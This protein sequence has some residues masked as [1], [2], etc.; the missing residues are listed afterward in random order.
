MTAAVTD[1]QA[2]IWYSIGLERKLGRRAREVFARAE[3]R[4]AVVYVPALVLV[5]I[6][7]SN[8]RGGLHCPDGFTR[9]AGR[10]L[11]SGAFLA[12]DL[13]SSIVMKAEELYAIPE[14]GDRLIAATA[15]H[16]ELPLI[17]NDPV[18]SSIPGMTT[19]W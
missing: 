17:T 5:E 11:R 18:I 9:W 10:L 8:Q 4:A 15:A 1:S 19:I 2:L 3:N 6:A 7:E 14:R 12:A 16:L 13:T